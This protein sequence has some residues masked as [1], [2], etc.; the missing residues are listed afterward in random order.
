MSDLELVGTMDTQMLSTAV[1][2]LDP[3]AS[4]IAMWVHNKRLHSGSVRTE[5]TYQ[6]TLNAFR[7]HLQAHGLELDS[8]RRQIRPYLQA[9]AGQGAGES[10][11]TLNQRLAIVSSFYTFARKNDLLFSWEEAEDGDDTFIRRRIPLDNPAD[12]V[13]RAKVI[14]Y[15]KAL[16]LKPAEV[17][18]KLRQ[19]DQTTPLGLR[20]YALLVVA[21][22]TGR[23]LAEL[24][25]L[26]WKDVKM[27]KEKGQEIV[28][29]RWRRAKGTKTLADRLEPEVGAAL[30]RYLRT[31]YNPQLAAIPAEAPIW[32]AFDF[33]RTATSG[34][35]R[36]PRRTDAPLGVRAISYLCQHHLGTGKVHV[37][38]HSFALGMK[39]AG[40]PVEAIQARLA[41]ESLETTAE[42]LPKLEADENPYAGEVAA[43]FGLR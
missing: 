43:I 29:L 32:L 22:T 9:W 31:V 36:T 10:G 5:H 35:Q 17:A 14:P 25:A 19:I 26:A 13:E 15:G 27:T 38:R 18:E 30:L 41:H 23:R 34:R 42:Y 8:P 1:A 4:A 37:T 6:K 2:S 21:F 40:A 24:A 16:A 12:Y 11:A 33:A 28:T 39:K 3:I 7:V 20:N